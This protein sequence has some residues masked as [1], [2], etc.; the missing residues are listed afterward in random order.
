M[1]KKIEYRSLENGSKVMVL[2]DRVIMAPGVWNNWFYDADQMQ[3]AFKNTDWN[4]EKNRYL[5]FD[6]VDV[7]TRDWTGIVENPHMDGSNLIG[8]LVISNDEVQK[9]VL[10]GAKWGISPKIFGMGD[11]R[12]G[13][14]KNFFFK[15][16]SFVLDP[17]CKLTFLN[18]E[19]K[20]ESEGIKLIPNSFFKLSK[21]GNIMSEEEAIKMEEIEKIADIVLDKMAERKLKEDMPE[22]DMDKPHSEEDC[23]DKENCPIHKEMTKKKEM[24]DMDKHEDEMAEVSNFE[25]VRKEKGMSVSEFYAIPLEPPSN[26]K[27]PIFDESHTKNALARINQ[28]QGVSP[29]QKASALRKIHA[30]AKQFGIETKEVENKMSEEE[31]TPTS[32][33][34]SKSTKDTLAE[35]QR[36]IKRMSQAGML[37][38]SFT[39][40]FNKY[41][42]TDADAPFEEIA[43]HY[44]KS[45]E[46]AQQKIEIQEL[47]DAKFASMDRGHSVT[48][49][50]VGTE[51]PAD[52]DAAMLQFLRDFQSGGYGHGAVTVELAMNPSKTPFGYGTFELSSTTTSTTSTRGTQFSAAP[53]PIQPIQFLKTVID[54][55][56][57]RLFFMQAVTQ[58]TLPENTF[59]LVVPYRS[60]YLADSSWQNA[61]Q[62]IAAGSELDATQINT[63]DGI[64]ITPTAENY[65]IFA[66]NK[67]IRTAGIP[68]IPYLREEL[69]YKYENGPDSTVR[70][71]ILGT[72][73]S[74]GTSTAPTE[75][76]NTVLGAQTIFGG[77]ATDASNSLDNGDILATTLLSKARTYLMSTRA[78]YWSGNASTLSATT[79]NPW[80]PTPSQPFVHYIAPE[81]EK[82]YLDETK[83]TN[84][85]EYGD[86]GPLLTGEIA[87][88]YLGV[89]IVSTTKVPGFVSGDEVRVQGSQATQDVT[90]H[91][92]G[93]VKTGV[94]GALVWGLKPTIKIYD[95]PNADQI[96]FQLS[97]DL[98]ASAIQADAIVRMAVTD[99]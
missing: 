29:E 58:Y 6:H 17:A 25:V 39:E 99:A 34:I 80:Y 70:N 92:C 40:F 60:K 56:K 85:A 71:A 61:G 22:D 54:A 83:F 15:N 98:G 50:Q 24:P 63:N 19:K 67:N 95:W 23:P 26:S 31:T 33:G 48:T 89:R 41:T 64:K 55:A 65:A 47:I 91:L 1:A 74:D 28:V 4:D 75:M 45:Q 35:N 88:T 69:V 8:D 46:L 49:P 77:D 66:T 72:I 73:T 97:M 10:M 76:S 96:R 87:Q 36:I 94:C 82:A 21:E 42:E 51:V 20:D 84:A 12:E 68:L 9:A 11:K 18:S 32:S 3:V 7:G 52:P 53:Y 2:K 38:K 13:T 79:K 37:D 30:K 90:G 43:Q 16:F 27:L 81:Q 5:Y 14:V 93:M 62:Q 44:K 78:Y 86:R 59:E 57:E